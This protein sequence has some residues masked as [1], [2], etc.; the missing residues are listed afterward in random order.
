M[1]R[2]YYRDERE[3]LTG[4]ASWEM[5]YRVFRVRTWMGAKGLNGSQAAAAR[6]LKVFPNELLAVHLM[7]FIVFP[8]CH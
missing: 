3:H 1:T 8:V 6:M 4:M 2:P 5:L 7:Y